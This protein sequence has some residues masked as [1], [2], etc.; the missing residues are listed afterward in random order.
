MS[1]YTE[2]CC[3]PLNCLLFSSFNIFNSYFNSTV[4]VA[5]LRTASFISELIVTRDGMD[6]LSRNSMLSYSE[7]LDVITYVCTR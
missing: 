6:K 4:Y 1:F 2:R 3:S 7:L 5:Q